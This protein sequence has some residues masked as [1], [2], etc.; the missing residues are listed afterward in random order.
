MVRKSRSKNTNI[1][2]TEHDHLLISQIKKLKT[3][4]TCFFNN[5]GGGWEDYISS[6]FRSRAIN[7]L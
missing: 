4:T 7:K 1:E 6:K 3:Q 2:L 5:K